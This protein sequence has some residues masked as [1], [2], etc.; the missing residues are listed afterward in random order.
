M[1]DQDEIQQQPEN[2]PEEEGVETA[3][4]VEQEDENGFRD[5]SLFHVHVPVYEG[6]M[7]LLLYVVRQR[8]I[9]L[10]ELPVGQVA[11]D[12]LD[13]VRANP[14]LDLDS[15]GEVLLVAAI[16]IRMKVR[17][18]LPRDEDEEAED[19]DAI[20]ARD[21]ELEEAYREIVAAARQLAE[22]EEVQRDYFPR[23]NAAALVEIDP[24]EQLLKNVT[25][26]TLAEA[27]REL[28]NRV[29]KTPVHQLAMFTLTI[30]D[31]SSMLLTRLR[32]R[33]R[34]GFADI[35]EHLKERLE[36]VVAFLAIL[37]L[38]RYRRIKI[39]QDELFGE[40][41][42]MRG[43]RF[44]ADTDAEMHDDETEEDRQRRGKIEEES[45]VEMEAFEAEQ[46]A[47]QEA[48]EARRAALDAEKAE[49]GDE[50]AVE[51]T[52]DAFDGEDEHF[53]LEG[54]D[55]ESEDLSEEQRPLDPAMYE[56]SEEDVDETDEPDN[57]KTIDE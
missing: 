31:M 15:A 33:D 6:P 4:L 46:R 51:G 44:E 28:Q 30:A 7:D 47:K 49:Q 40:I 18:L 54:S 50:M 1:N 43:P 14:T 17:A 32:Q 2:T 20:V 16:L 27:F 22:S 5:D 23:G 25:L 36:V 3:N 21:E 53:S 8:S 48:R 10:I 12:F 11:Q 9:D 29:D 13:Y 26:V 55:S 19:L 52:D 34:L 57:N 56:D 24:A 39:T 42:V 41:W 38:I 35:A 45:R 37:E